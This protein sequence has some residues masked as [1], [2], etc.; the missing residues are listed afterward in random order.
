MS[1]IVVMIL[2]SLLIASLFLGAFIWAA[3]S[4]QFR[5]SKTPGLRILFE[6]PSPVVK[7]KKADKEGDIHD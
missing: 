2:A 5:D 4:G 3:L 7:D 6:P 1:A